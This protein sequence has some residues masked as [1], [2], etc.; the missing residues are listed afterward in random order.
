MVIDGEGRISM[1]T[2]KRRLLLNFVIIIVLT[3]TTLNS[4]IYLALRNIYY[5]NIF[6]MLTN[7]IKISSELYSKYF[8]KESLYDN[9]LNGVDS[10]I[11]QN[12]IEVQ[13][14]DNTGKIIFDSIGVI[15]E[16]K[17]SD[18]DEALVGKVGKWIGTVDYD[19]Y[20]VMAV[21]YPLYKKGEIIGGL[22]FITTL[23]EVNKDLRGILIILSSLGLI[24][25][26]ISA[27]ISIL[28]SDSIVIPITNITN[29]AQKM[30]HGEYNHRCNG[31]H[32]DEI[33]KLSTTLNY[34]ADEIVKR[35]KLKDEFISSVSHELRTPLTSIK[36]WAVTLKAD[37][38]I[39]KE[40]LNDGLDIIEG[41]CDRLTSMVEELLDFSKLS[42]GKV[43]L[44]LSEVNIKGLLM[45]I[46]KQMEPRATRENKVFKVDVLDEDLIVYADRNRL[47]QVFINLLDNAFNFTNVGDAIYLKYKND[48]SKIT[49]I[50]EDTGL[51]IPDDE[52]PHV[53]EKFYKGKSSRSK[54]GIGLSVCKDI[55]EK[56][57]GDISIESK[58]GQGTRVIINIPV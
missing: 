17:Y 57:N 43:E 26:F 37:E 35:E 5:S 51:G 1:R 8:S 55:I 10:F 27:F 32:F 6:N 29:V 36:G 53:F 49:L 19:N 7:Q 11:S 18:I 45:E 25:T 38:N 39:D 28:L 42:S 3:V 30:A 16:E 33:E 9:V 21:S 41:E 24:V 50:V 52:L 22:R 47:K 46:R 48:G 12:D 13:I 15:E 4:V 23:R 20:S 2:I 34:M 58:V 54:N 44:K 40:L 56:M 14:F 31:A